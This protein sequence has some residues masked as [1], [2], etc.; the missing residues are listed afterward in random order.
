MVPIAFLKVGEAAR[1][2]PV[3][4]GERDHLGPFTIELLERLRWCSGLGGDSFHLS[5]SLM[6]LLA[7][8]RASSTSAW[9]LLDLGGGSVW[10]GSKLGA[11]EP[12]AIVLDDSDSC[13]SRSWLS[14]SL[15]SLPTATR[16][17]SSVE[18]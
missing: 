15:R 12:R 13:L 16:A 5:S 7:R 6:G 3:G 8:R 14:S 2:L 4:E 17:C 18:A 1:G 10:A 11:G 9:D